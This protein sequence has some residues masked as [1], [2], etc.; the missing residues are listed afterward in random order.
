MGVVKGWL[1]AAP[2]WKGLVISHAGTFPLPKKYNNS[3]FIQF[4]T[5]YSLGASIKKSDLK[6]FPQA[7]K[8]AMKGLIRKLKWFTGLLS[9]TEYE[10]EDLLAG[11]AFSLQ[12]MK[13]Q[14]DAVAY[15]YDQDIE[16]WYVGYGTTFTDDPDYDER[17]VPWFKHVAVAN[18]TIGDPACMAT[19]VTNNA[20]VTGTTGTILDM[21]TILTSTATGMTIDFVRQTFQPIIRAFTLFKDTNNGR[22][23]VHSTNFYKTT[24]RFVFLAAPELIDELESVHPYDG[25]K[26][27]LNTNIKAEMEKKNITLVPCDD[28]T[29]ALA[30]EAGGGQGT[31]QFGFVADFNRNF[32]IGVAQKVKWDEWKE[33]PKI[34]SD[35]VKKMSARHCAFTMPYWNG[36][37]WFKAFFA[38]YFTYMNDT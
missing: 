33:I 15:Q 34:V 10:H 5:L 24:A 3:P 38:G 13:T 31:C 37:Y 17:W 21:N 25:E 7:V 22:R 18:A 29:A 11:D 19:L 30:E 4:D 2:W 20:D 8:T 35:W 32:K 27:L 12:D 23:M 16:A 9:N 28:F 26:I 1:E 6:E 14:I 36:T